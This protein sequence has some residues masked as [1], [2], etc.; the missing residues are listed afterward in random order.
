MVDMRNAYRILIEKLEGRKRFRKSSH[1]WEDTIKMDLRV[2]T[3]S[4]RHLAK[5]RDQ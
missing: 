2:M 4:W 1:K 3:E 5:D